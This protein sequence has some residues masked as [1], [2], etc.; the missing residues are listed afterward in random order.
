MGDYFPS[1]VLEVE[2]TGLEVMAYFNDWPAY[3]AAETT[4]VKTGS[5]RLNAMTLEGLNVLRVLARP[6]EGDGVPSPRAHLEVRLFRM[7]GPDDLLGIF[8]HVHRPVFRS[9]G[10]LTG[11]RRSDYQE[12][13]RHELGFVQTFGRWKWENGQPYMPEDRDEILGYLRNMHTALATKNF[14]A[15]TD[16]SAVKLEEVARATGRRLDLVRADNQ[17]TMETFADLEGWR[18]EPL[19]LERTLLES[20]AGGRLVIARAPDGGPPLMAQVAGTGPMG[21]FVTFGRVDG[22]WVAVR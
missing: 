17:Q 3:E 5:V 7:L 11:R 15:F 19:D 4:E 16:L 9:L 2:S 14:A 13:A 20:C 1:Y 10:D 12:V 18:V 21:F 8:R 22:K 6:L